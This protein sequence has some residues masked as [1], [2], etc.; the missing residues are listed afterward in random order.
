MMRLWTAHPGQKVIYIAPL[1]VG[2]RSSWSCTQAAHV[3][4]ARAFSSQDHMHGGRLSP[5]RFLQ[6]QSF[7]GYTTRQSACAYL[8]P[9]P[10]SPPLPSPCPPPQALVRERIT[11]WGA[12][13]CP[14]LGKKMVELTGGGQGDAVGIKVLGYDALATHARPFS[15]C[16]HC[17]TPHVRVQTTPSKRLL[18]SNL[19]H[20]PCSSPAPPRP[21]PL[22]PRRLHARPAR[23]AERR[24]HHLHPREVGRHLARLADQGV[25]QEGAYQR[26]APSVWVWVLSGR[27]LTARNSV[28]VWV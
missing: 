2:S 13:L 25:R 14:L 10:S 4:L 20:P 21:R 11:D 22:P 3:S 26:P 7:L 19:P 8:P 28:C 5:P 18:F 15:T 12:K 23:A 24:H 1:K 9:N 17:P 16:G 27:G 6:N